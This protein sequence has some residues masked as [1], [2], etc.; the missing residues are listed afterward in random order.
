MMK[1]HKLSAAIRDKKCKVVYAW[2]WLNNDD[3]VWIQIS[4]SEALQ[5]T[6]QAKEDGLAEVLAFEKKGEI[7]LG[8]DE[9]ENEADI[10]AGA[11]ADGRFAAEEEEEDLGEEEEEEETLDEEEEEDVNEEEEEEEEAPAEQ[12]SAAKK[13]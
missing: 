13:R 5:F 3:G 10:P 8:D 7:F 12:R 2:L 9:E 1:P 11:E 6:D 4:K